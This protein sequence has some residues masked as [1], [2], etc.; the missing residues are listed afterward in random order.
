[1]RGST[2]PNHNILSNTIFPT[3]DEEENFIIKVDVQR[4]SID[5]IDDDNGEENPFGKKK[6]KRKRKTLETGLLREI[7]KFK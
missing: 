3:D 1:M 6:K 2:F 5:V 7:L 4:N